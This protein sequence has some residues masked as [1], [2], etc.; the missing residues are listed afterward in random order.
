MNLVDESFCLHAAGGVCCRLLCYL[1]YY[2]HTH[3]T[4]SMCEMHEIQQN[5]TM[6]SKWYTYCIAC[7]M[8]SEFLLIAYEMFLCIRCYVGL[9]EC[10]RTEFIVHGLNAYCTANTFVPNWHVEWILWGNFSPN[11]FVVNNCSKFH[12]NIQI[13][14][15]FWHELWFGPYKFTINQ[16]FTDKWDNWN[17][18][19][20]N[21]RNSLITAYN[22][23]IEFKLTFHDINDA[24]N[25]TLF[26]DKTFGCILNGIHTI[27]DL[28]DLIHIQ[29]FHKVIVQYSRFDELAWSKLTIQENQ[30]KI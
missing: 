6:Q 2:T 14:G 7:R 4:R 13:E 3:N 5:F 23:W 29:I 8:K 22:I 25:I 18:L 15:F 30:M 24:T 19:Y 9:F 11:R 17:V 28:A 1:A 10:Y 21:N 12:Q 27:D 20:T 16:L 26:D